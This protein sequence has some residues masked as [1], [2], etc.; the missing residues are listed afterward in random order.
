MISALATCGKYP[1]C[2]HVSADLVSG[3][4]RVAG[5]PAVPFVLH[6]PDVI[7]MSYAVP[8]PVAAVFPDGW[9]P[10]YQT[11]ARISL[12]LH[13][14]SSVLSEVCVG[15]FSYVVSSPAHRGSALSRSVRRA[16]ARRRDAWRSTALWPVNNDCAAMHEDRARCDHRQSQPGPHRPAIATPAILAFPNA[17]L[18]QSEGR[19][20]GARLA[21]AAHEALGKPRR[22]LVPH[23]Y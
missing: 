16:P 11:L 1:S 5:Q 6:F 10:A 12:R 17:G 19:G 13:Y 23:G 2:R 8:A 14:A 3:G 7:A 4:K 15:A 22:R 20:P 18:G 9:L 21:A